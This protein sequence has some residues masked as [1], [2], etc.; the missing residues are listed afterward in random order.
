MIN[1][2]KI[3]KNTKQFQALTSLSI[4]EFDELLLHFS[5]K[6]QEHEAQYLYNGKRRLNQ[7]LKHPKSK[8]PTE[9]HKLFFILYY[10]KN[11]PIQ[12]AL[13]ATFEMQQPVANVWIKRIETVL[14]STLKSLGLVPARNVEA[15]HDYLANH[16]EEDHL[17]LDATERTVPRSCDY[18]EQKEH[19]SGKK[20]LI[21]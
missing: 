7:P 4:Q 3:R 16:P 14:N 2:E 20:K 8:L 19:Y 21:R 13:A 5:P 12:E 15:L 18:E 1:Y 6:W 9:A 17:L 10:Y 11:N